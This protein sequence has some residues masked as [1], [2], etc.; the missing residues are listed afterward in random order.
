M[1]SPDQVRLV[2]RK[3]AV[4]SGRN[5]MTVTSSV[6]SECPVS[7]PV[8]AHMPVIGRVKKKHVAIPM[9]IAIMQAAVTGVCL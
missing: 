6:S 5:V 4:P 9:R 3:S 1:V 7:R 8:Q 2:F